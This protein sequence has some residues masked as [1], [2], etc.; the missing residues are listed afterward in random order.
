MDSSLEIIRDQNGY[1]HHSNGYPLVVIFDSKHREDKTPDEISWQEPVIGL[2]THE[3]EKGGTRFY[4]LI[5]AVKPDIQY[6][7]CPYPAQKSEGQYTATKICQHIPSSDLPQQKRE[8]ESS[9]SKPSDVGSTSIHNVTLCKKTLQFSSEESA[10]QPTSVPRQPSVLLDP[11]TTFPVNME[12]Y[13]HTLIHQYLSLTSNLAKPSELGCR[14]DLAAQGWFPLAMT[15]A[16]LFHA[17]LC[18]S[19]LYMDL[20]MGRRESLEKVKHMK[21]VVHL[22]S[23]RLRDPGSELSD[24]TIVAVAHLAEFEASTSVRNF[25][26]WSLHMDGLHKMVQIRGF[27]ALNE[28]LKSKIWRADITGC[29]ATLSKPRFT[30]I[31]IP[32]LSLPPLLLKQPISALCDGMRNIIELFAFDGGLIGIISELQYLTSALN[33]ATMDLLTVDR[34]VISIQYHLLLFQSAGYKSSQNAALQEVCCIG[35]L[36]YLETV[37]HFSLCLQVGK[38][39]ASALTDGVTIQKLKSCLDMADMNTAQTRVLFLW[40]MFLGGAA[41]AGTKDRAWFVARL[42]KIVMELQIYNWKDAKSSLMKFLWAGRVH[43][44]SCKDLWDE[45]LITMTVLFG[46]DC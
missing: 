27:A 33:N 36:V 3:P 2:H 21:E 22:L 10:S 40:I 8:H 15:D 6:R 20:L 4:I 7:H 17:I 45:V 26:N 30:A 39:P 46:G 25:A 11:F 16:A 28:N 38:F 43:E 44:N 19:A 34:I 29:I 24:S 23:T 14:Q 31:E 41:V 42:V 5:V 37:Y 12:P 35:A 32:S 1:F 18:G 9:V 13:M